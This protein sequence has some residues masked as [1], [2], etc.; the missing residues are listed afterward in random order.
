MDDRCCTAFA[1]GVRQ[2]RWVADVALNAPWGSPRDALNALQG[3]GLAVA[4]VIKYR[5]IQ[6]RAK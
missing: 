2:R 6:A 4:E 3:L 1:Q 5:Y